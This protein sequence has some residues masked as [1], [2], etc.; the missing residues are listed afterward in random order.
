MVFIVSWNGLKTD[1]ML[2]QLDEIHLEGALL[3]HGS[4]NLSDSGSCESAASKRNRSHVRMSAE[5]LADRESFAEDE[6]ANPVR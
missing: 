3:R 1:V 4:S 2:E 6:I 5:R